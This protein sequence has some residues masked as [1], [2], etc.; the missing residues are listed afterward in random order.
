VDIRLDEEQL[1]VQG[2]VR[3]LVRA[4]IAPRAAEIDETEE[5]PWD[6]VEMFRQQDLFAL[7]FP[8]EYGGLSGSALTLNVAIEEI[9][10]ACATSALILAVQALGGYPI[11]LAG[12]DEQRQRWLPD[13]ASGRRLAA[14]ALS[15]PGAGSDPGGMVTRAI[16][17]GDDYVLRGSKIWITDGGVAD[18]IVVFATTG[19]GSR[20]KG[21][22]AF[23]VDDARN[24]HGLTA[25]TIHGKL[26]IRGSNTAELHFDDVVV[27]AENR[28]GEEGEGFRIAMRVLDRSRPGVAAQALGIAQGALD[29]AVGYARERRQFGRAIAE[30]QGLQFMLADMEAQTAAARALVYH[31]SSLIDQK[32]PDAGHAAAICKLFAADTAMKVTTDAVQVLGG[33]GYV[34][35]Y[36]VERMMRDAKITQIYEGTNQ[37]QRV[38]IARDLLQG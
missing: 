25:T 33:Y 36:P 7:P 27:P 29:Y 20:A 12:S 15:E 13:L 23:V 24:A 6:V 17:R 4:R 37:I 5:F 2:S 35:E 14:Y 11:M 28:L 9:A 8:A 16:R 1:M 31:A 32:S 26:G 21:I 3:E 19:P 34:R 30:F 38:V 10:K 22:S 18:T